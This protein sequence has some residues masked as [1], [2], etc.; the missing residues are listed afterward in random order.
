MQRTLSRTHPRASAARAAAYDRKLRV[1]SILGKDDGIDEA[2]SIALPCPLDS[3]A[4]RTDENSSIA[5]TWLATARPRGGL[6][7]R[8]GSLAHGTRRARASLVFWLRSR[9]GCIHVRSPG[10][11]DRVAPPPLRDR[12]SRVC[13]PSLQHIDVL[14]QEQALPAWTDRRQHRK[15][16]R[17]ACVAKQR[18]LEKARARGAPGGHAHARRGEERPLQ[19]ECPPHHHQNENAGKCDDSA[20]WTHELRHAPPLL[21]VVDPLSV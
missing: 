16:L 6:S 11:R 20:T 21:R 1:D 15:E 7:R 10:L 8:S 5:L 13:S 18:N 2:R 19:S 4:S 9:A 17:V 3:D 14:L 12:A